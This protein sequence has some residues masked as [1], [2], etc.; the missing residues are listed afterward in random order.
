MTSQNLAIK[1]SLTHLYLLGLGAN[2]GNPKQQIKSALSALQKLEVEILQTSPL[3]LSS[4]MGPQNQP[5]FINAC[6]WISSAE[7]PEPLMEFCLKTEKDLGRTRD[8]KWGP[9]TI[10][11]DLLWWSGG[12]FQ[13]P[14]VTLPHPG[15]F[16]RDFVLIPAMQLDHFEEWVL[17]PTQKET[18]SPQSH[19][20]LSLEENWYP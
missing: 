1:K 11:L 9:R 10:D 5:D 2:I 17:G 12:T 20:K 4:P 8:T 14:T 6:A 18:I 3:V 7:K 15:L 13:S 16:Q 19:H